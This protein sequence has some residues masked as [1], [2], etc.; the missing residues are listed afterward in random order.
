MPYARSGSW[1]K[2][3]PRELLPNE[4]RH[5][6]QDQPRDANIAD[7]RRHALTHLLIY[8]TNY[9]A[10][11]HHDG[12]LPIDGLP[13]ELLLDQIQVRCRCTRCG[14][15]GADVRPDWAPVIGRKKS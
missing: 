12:T 2:R 3:P 4:R 8:C 11:C 9:P 13:D 15:K 7:C 6:H 1:R 10:Y 5:E 14:K